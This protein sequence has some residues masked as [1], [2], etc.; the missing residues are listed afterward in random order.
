MGRGVVGKNWGY[1]IG[2]KQAGVKK[3]DTKH[4]QRP[5]NLKPHLDT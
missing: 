1:M 3:R 2:V 4:K 5:F